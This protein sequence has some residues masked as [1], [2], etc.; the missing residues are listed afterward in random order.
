MKRQTLQSKITVLL[1]LCIMI[2]AGIIVVY[3]AISAGSMIR[4]AV[5]SAAR[6]TA[7]MTSD[8][9][10]AAVGAAEDRLSARAEAQAFKVQA[11]LNTAMETA[12]TFAYLMEGLKAQVLSGFDRERLFLLLRGLLD[13]HPEFMGVFLCWEPDAY[14][15]MDW[16][17]ASSPGHDA[18]GRLIPYWQRDFYEH[19]SMKAL[20]DY[21]SETAYPN[22]VRHGE[23]YLLPKETKQECIINPYPY[24]SEDEDIF[25]TSLVVPI[26]VQEKFLGVSGVNLRLDFL[27]KLAENAADELYGGKG[28]VAIVSAN[29]TLA[30]LS[31]SPGD[32]GREVKAVYNIPETDPDSAAQG[33]RVARLSDGRMLFSY[34]LIIGR[35]AIPWSVNVIVPQEVILSEVRAMKEKMT[36]E[37][38]DLRDSLEKESRKAL[39]KQFI[40][41]ILFTLAGL[42]AG[43][44]TARSIAMPITRIV[45]GLSQ[46]AGRMTAASAHIS[47]E[48]QS[49]SRGASEQAS[50]I[51]EAS[52][53]LTEISSV[54]RK[55]AE[56]ANH[57]ETLMKDTETVIR[58]A[59]V[60]VSELRLSMEDIEAASEKT[61]NI[62]KLIDAI[63]FQTNLLALNAAVEAV[64]ARAAGAGFAVVADEV[65]TL[66]MRAAEAA[67]N[68][69]ELIGNTVSRVKIGSELVSR[70]G[71]AF[72][73]VAETHERVGVLIMEIASGSDEQSRGIETVVGAVSEI[74][75]VTQQNA[76]GAEESAAASEDMNEQAEQVKHYVDELAAMTGN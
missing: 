47:S 26:M 64:R 41:G 28:T 12:R 66:A 2:T 25:I 15:G 67:G 69:S 19:V 68:T 75:S 62:I 48:S 72:D 4:S 58:E 52:S 44:V 70:T 37:V 8:M 60:S 20:K 63:A 45:Q 10:K 17:F 36:R 54:T 34:P 31:R 18:T 6:M 56:N 13:K 39:L 59:R 73:R 57:A 49:V 22:G 40:I 50:D 5:N 53:F 43:Y 51:E 30:A 16:G 33:K 38:G 35:T 76:A 55:T 21:E 3:S 71:T 74:N 42:A 65:R 7:D 14:D 32:I 1:G 24:K 27:Q 23:Y 11:V 61:Y 29:G 9:E 46:G